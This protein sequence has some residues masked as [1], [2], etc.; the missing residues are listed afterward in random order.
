MPE[1]RPKR[2][3]KFKNFLGRNERILISYGGAGSG[4]SH[5]VAQKIV[6]K[7]YSEHNK[8]FLVT[9]KTLPSLR[10]TA[11]KL[12]LRLLDEYGLPYK[13]NKSDLELTCSDNEILFKSLD[14]YEKIKSYEAD[15]IWVEEAT[16]ITF[17]DFT[18]LNLRLG[19][20]ETDHKNQMFLTFNPISRFH[21]INKELFEKPR[22][23]QAILQSTYKD[24]P[25]LSKD[26]IDELKRLKDQDN[27]L[28]GIYA[29]GQW[30]TLSNLIYSN[31]EIVDE[32]KW[33]KEFDETIY[34]LD[35]GFNVPCALLEIGYLGENIYEKE[36]LYE[37]HLT[38]SELIEYLKELIL[39]REN[40]IYADSAEPARIQEIED[41]GFNVYPTLKGKNSVKD[42]IDFIKTHKRYIHK[43]STNM[44]AEL[45]GYKWREKNGEVLDEPVKFRDHL[46]DAERGARWTYFQEVGYESGGTIH[47]KS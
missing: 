6:E 44:I 41:A 39:D 42:G 37:T 14:D 45:S 29:L 46:M 2:I 47:F 16:D 21:W 43:N 30:M 36:L 8:S 28:Y 13:F 11:M 34:G 5:S 40:D 18:Q 17:D 26:Y 20:V 7:F 32:N 25:F 12:I 3:K 23:N 24:N 9:R 22:V 15:Y 10:I 35:F 27:E 1:I 19:R 38:N 4:K 31:Y 33:P